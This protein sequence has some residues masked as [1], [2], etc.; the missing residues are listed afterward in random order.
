MEKVLVTGGAGFIGSNL[1]DRLIELGFYVIVIDNEFSDAH[2]QFYWNENADNYKYDIRDYELIE[3]LFRDVKFVFHLAAEARIQPAI[4]NPL[5]AVEINVVGTCN[6]LQ[7]ARVNN[8]ERVIYSSTSSAYGLK[9]TPPLAEDMPNDCLNPYSV[10]KVSGEELCKMYTNLFGLK[11]ITFRYFNVYGERQPTRGQYAPVIGL[12]L[13]QKHNNVDMTV[14]GDG[15]QTRDYTH[16]SDVVEANIAAS[17]CES[18]FG[19]IYNI[20]CGKRYSVLDLVE[21][22]GG[23]HVHIPPRPGE[24]RETE[25]NIAKAKKILNWQPKIKLKDWLKSRR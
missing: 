17:K 2:E 15:L 25:A 8:V 9:N 23:T 13:K 10:S 4:E 19:E 18:G 11:T 12:F 20:G 14:V 1:V 5:T 16:V 21:M 22:I 3:P 24:S 6:V 7:A